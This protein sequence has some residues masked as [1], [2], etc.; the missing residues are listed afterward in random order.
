MGRSKCSQVLPVSKQVNV[1]LTVHHDLAIYINY[2]LDS[3]II[4]Y[5]YTITFLY[6]FRAINAHLQE[7]TMYTCS[8]WY[9]H[10]LR[11]IVVAGRCT[12]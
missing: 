2:Q 12:V 7:V 10:S 6:T 5:S 8:I 3:Q 1:Y 11:A 4:I 9:C